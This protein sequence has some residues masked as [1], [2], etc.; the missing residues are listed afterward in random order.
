MSQSASRVTKIV[1]TGGGTAGHVMP[2]LALL[3]RLREA[4]WDV[5]YVGSGGIEQDLITSAGIPFH[6]IQV[7]KLRRYLSIQNFIDI[8]KVVLGTIQA[9]FVLLRLRPQIVFSKGGFVSVPVALAA[10]ILGIPVVTHESD[11]T[12]GLA[13][14][15]I[16]KF[17]TKILYSFPETSRHV[18]AEISKLVGSP[19]REELLAGTKEKGLRFCGFPLD[20]PPVLLVMGGS[21]G[22]VRIN[23]ALLAD[24]PHLVK[25][26]RVIHLAGRG[27]LLDFKHA[28]YR[29]FEFVK[30]EM[31]DV[32]AAADVVVSRAGANS[33]FEILALRKPLLLIPL[34]SGSRGDQLDNAESFARN[35]WARV[36][37]E[38]SLGPGVL[39]KSVQQIFRDADSLV[40]AQSEFSGSRDSR[41]VFDEIAA[42]VKARG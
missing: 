1:L 38:S 2:H 31:P 13:N 12:P 35:G 29:A 30:S 16:E 5:H 32:L 27:K 10:K 25:S 22:A 20:G 11:V 3:P 36:L 24:L 28:N 18:P 34:K 7:G 8:L 23:E 19:V 21:Q 17:A 14:R 39:E 37:D 42:V 4:G 41:A 40:K 33:I 26:W 6:R 15:I 9:F